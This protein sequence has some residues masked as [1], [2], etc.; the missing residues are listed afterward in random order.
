MGDFKRYSIVNPEDLTPELQADIEEHYS[1]AL[2]QIKSIMQH[3]KVTDKR[4]Q[5][6]K[7][8]IPSEYIAFHMR[9]IISFANFYHDNFGPG[10][11]QL[12]LLNSANE[13]Y[14]KNVR[15][16]VQNWDFVKEDLHIHEIIKNYFIIA[17]QI[18]ALT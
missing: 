13:T 7:L 18:V 12:G 2:K 11:K 15:T 16:I 8:E 1:K 5:T 6:N 3:H 14:M 17:K 10:E 4:Y 9:I